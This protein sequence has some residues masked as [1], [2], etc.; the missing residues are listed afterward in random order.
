MSATA[1]QG[2][3]HFTDKISLKGSLNQKNSGS[4]RNTNGFNTTKN[5]YKSKLVYVN[6][7][8]I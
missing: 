7:L 8:I 2:F 3:T 4:D 5:N 6:M 1:S